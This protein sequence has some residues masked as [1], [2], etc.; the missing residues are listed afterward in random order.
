MNSAVLTLHDSAAQALVDAMFFS[1]HSEEKRES[2]GQ[3]GQAGGEF[4]LKPEVLCI[5]RME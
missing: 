4:H 1:T 2:E 3:E 5:N